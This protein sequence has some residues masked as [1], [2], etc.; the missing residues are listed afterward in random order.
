MENVFSH[1]HFLVNENPKENITLQEYGTTAEIREPA[2]LAV[3][4]GPGAQPR[5]LWSSLVLCSSFYN[6]STLALVSRAKV[7]LHC[8]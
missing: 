6:S 3:P 5:P 7:R 2:P 8:S 4:M 1:Y